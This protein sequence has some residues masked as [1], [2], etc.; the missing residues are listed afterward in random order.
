MPKKINFTN[1]MMKTLHNPAKKNN[2]KNHKLNKKKNHLKPLP[3][4]NPKWEPLHPFN[5]KPII[6]NL[7]SNSIK[8]LNSKLSQSSVVKIPKKKWRNLGN[9]SM[10]GKNNLMIL[11]PNIKVPSFLKIDTST[12]VIGKIRKEM[13]RENS[14]GRMVPSMKAIGKII[15]PMVMED[16]SMEMGMSTQG[17]GKMIELVEKASIYPIVE[18]NMKVFGKMINNKVKAKR[19][20]K[21][22]QHIKVHI[23]KEKK[24]EKESFIGEM[25][26]VMKENFFKTKL[27]GK[28]SMCGKM[29]V[30][31]KEIG[32]TIGWKEQEFLHGQMEE[33]MRDNTKMIKKMG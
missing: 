27:V 11:M 21:M 23:K 1:T 20:G 24:M 31:M 29:V 32:S 9:L 14:S 2:F 30:F 4:N 17:N 13:E 25:I 22:E 7:I 3:T 8:V 19:N 26:V 28:E 5:P 12:K 15:L 16:L 10:I 6:I 33:N 18:Q